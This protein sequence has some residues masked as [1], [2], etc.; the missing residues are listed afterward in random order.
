MQKLQ[1]AK[2]NPN[3]NQDSQHQETWA[4]LSRKKPQPGPLTDQGLN[5]VPLQK[6]ILLKRP[7]DLR[8]PRTYKKALTNIKIA[9]F[10]ENC[11]EDNLTEN[12][13]DLIIEELGRCSVRLQWENCHT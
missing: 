5:L 6:V 13:Q 7:R 2:D 4:Y 3:E 1:K 9:I 8:K 10:K 12:E 11:P